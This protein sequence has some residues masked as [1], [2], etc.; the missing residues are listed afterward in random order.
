M[1]MALQDTTVAFVGQKLGKNYS[2]A[3]VFYEASRTIANADAFP[4]LHHSPR[5]LTSFNT[6][7]LSHLPYTF[8][9]LSAFLSFLF[10]CFLSQYSFGGLLLIIAGDQHASPPDL[11]SFPQ[12][13]PTNHVLTCPRSNT[14]ALRA[15]SPH[16]P[17]R[18]RFPAPL[19]PS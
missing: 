1:G 13:Q 3:K 10:T 19:L 7:P 9:F 14:L 5:T 8:H 6:K 16:R 12:S 11:R 18:V 17:P 15:Q 2:L 4:L